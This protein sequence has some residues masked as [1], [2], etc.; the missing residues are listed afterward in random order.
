MARD[1]KRLVW[2][3]LA[4]LVLV[5]AVVTGAFLWYVGDYYHAGDVAHEALAGSRDVEVSELPDGSTAFV[6]ANP[7]CGMVFYPGGKVEPEAYAPLL[8]D[9]A[10]QG[11]LCVLVRPAFNL[12]ILD[13]N[14]ADG[15]I[16]QFP[17]VDAW[18][19]G[20][21]SLGGVAAASYLAD[22]LDEFEGVVLLA[23]YPTVDLSATSE[24]VLRVVGTNDGVL[25]REK[26]EAARELLPPNT[27]ELE[28]E[29]GNHAQFGDYGPQDGDGEA[30]LPASEQRDLTAL[31]IVGMGDPEVVVR[32]AA[33]EAIDELA[34]GEAL[35]GDDYLLLPDERLSGLVLAHEPLYKVCAA[36]LEGVAYELGEVS[37]EGDVATV[38]VT[39]TR[40]D[41]FAAFER[42]QA[43][44]AAYA[45]TEEGMHE[46]AVREDINQRAR[47]LADWLLVYLS[48]HLD[49]D[50]I[51]TLE[52]TATAHLSRGSDGV[53]RL[54]FAEN[55][56]LLGALFSAR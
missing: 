52:I 35:V 47:Y 25:D 43:D 33:A 32:A 51:E 1:K 54:D 3:V 20:G 39:V 9:C 31:A 40:P 38:G 16:G 41:L 5:I 46:V 12:A 21:H 30:T 4:S 17:E 13:A 42:A 27:R 36:A 6:P 26:Y 2:R 37:I 23:S 55:P 48:G 44:V 45:A 24:Q 28:L 15:M 14:A 22:H 29:G 18:Y 49:D 8:L 50:D 11:V 34:A 7:V 19:L 56:E 10:E 53:W